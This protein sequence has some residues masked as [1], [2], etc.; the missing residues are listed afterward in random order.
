[1]R[2]CPVLIH[3]RHDAIN[4]IMYF[5]TG[6]IINMLMCAGLNIILWMN[7]QTIEK[8]R[9][10]FSANI[11]DKEALISEPYISFYVCLCI[12]C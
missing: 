11:K 12:S 5:C 2:M 9:N 3:C 1:M 10:I 6:K 8:E 7:L 4:H